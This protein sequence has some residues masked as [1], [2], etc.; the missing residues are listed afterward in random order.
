MRKTLVV[1]CLIGVFAFVSMVNAQT[2][3]TPQYS[4]EVLVNPV[5]YYPYTLKNLSN[6]PVVIY[7]SWTKKFAMKYEL[8]RN[9]QSPDVLLPLGEKVR[10]IAYIQAG[11][12]KGTRPEEIGAY[13][14]ESYNPKFERGWLV[15]YKP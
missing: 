7:V 4:K 10:V 2:V 6:S 8:D 5:V 13:Y 1:V 9:Q 11:S 14:Y 3:V 15:G 12:Q